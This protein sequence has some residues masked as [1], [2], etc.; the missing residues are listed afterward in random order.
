MVNSFIITVAIEISK[1]ERSRY[2]ANKKTRKPRKPHDKQEAKK[3]IEIHKI[4]IGT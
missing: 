3:A 1:A 2:M 4:Y